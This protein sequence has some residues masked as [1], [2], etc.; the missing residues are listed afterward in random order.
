MRDDG[1]HN[2]GVL[3][4]NIYRTKIQ[5]LLRKLSTIFKQKTTQWECFRNKEPNTNMI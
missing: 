3:G 4:D 1:L 5:I 2:D